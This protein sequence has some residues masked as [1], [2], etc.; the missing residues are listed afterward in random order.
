MRLHYE[1]EGQGAA[2][3]I[4]HGLMG[5][6]ENWRLI[7]SALAPSFQVIC[8]DLPNHGRSYHTNRFDLHTI[9]ADVLETLD[10]IGVDEA[11]V[12]GH[13]LGGKAAMQLATDHAR[14]VRGV[15][16]VDISPRAIQPLHLFALRACERLDLAAATR[17]SELDAELAQYLPQ[18]ETRGFLLKNVTRNG[19]G[20]FQWRVPLRYL[21]GNYRIVSDAPPLTMPYHGAAL[22]IA[23]E[24]SPF[25]MMDDQAVINRWF[26][27]AQFALIPAAGHLVHIDQPQ[28]FL[29]ILRSFLALI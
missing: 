25:K 2:V 11:V 14:R 20:H 21:I 6:C 16:V 9:S 10:A 19:D 12:V 3:V 4:L 18:A 23:G 27:Q 29:A 24:R 5:S 22:F 8:M 17:R 7:R 26:T 1:S 28:V 15:V 13:S